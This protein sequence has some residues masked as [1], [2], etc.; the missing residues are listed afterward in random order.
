MN[1]QANQIRFLLCL[2]AYENH[3]LDP[4][5]Q[6]IISDMHAYPD[7]AE[8][9]AEL[10]EGTA[11][12]DI[13]HS[14]LEGLSATMLDVSVDGTLF[15]AEDSSFA[16]AFREIVYDTCEEVG[17]HIHFDGF[18]YEE[19]KQISADKEV[20]K[21]KLQNGELELSYVTHDCGERICVLTAGQALKLAVLSIELEV[22]AYFAEIKDVL[23]GKRDTDASE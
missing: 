22:Y 8:L 21:R 15:P 16:G 14:Q 7:N 13:V 9:W 11:W 18:S 20:F 12:D 19:A 3:M 5:K 23:F 17:M 10:N 1:K 6:G 2:G 4:D